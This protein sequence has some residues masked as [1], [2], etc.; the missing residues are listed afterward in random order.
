MARAKKKQV[1][2]DDGWTV[3]AGSGSA[4]DDEGSSDQLQDARPQ[5]VVNGLTVE[6][7]VDEFRDMEKRWKKTSCARNLDK[8][9]SLKDWSVR[10]AVCIGIG[11]FSL[12]WEHRYRS[13]WQLV[14]FTA[15]AGI[16]T[17]ENTNLSLH[18]QEPAFTAI[19]AAFLATLNISV[20][21]SSIQD[22]ISTS[23]FVF[24]PFVDWFLLLPL[25]LQAKDPELYIGNEV[26][27]N[28]RAFAN[29][30][31]KREVLAECNRLGKAFR[32]GRERRKV[33]DFELHGS[34]L[35]GLVMYWKDV[36]SDEE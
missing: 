4:R 21:T 5:K 1:Q 6:K 22:H 9:L 8:M 12:D 33:P 36:D 19:D 26:L 11:S 3:V 16:L 28:Y 30:Q 34:A 23:S 29:T 27:D 10:N 32:V 24:A 7:L 20:L 14:L 35:D 13:L 15:V 31:E 18:A 2:T 17:P 25:F